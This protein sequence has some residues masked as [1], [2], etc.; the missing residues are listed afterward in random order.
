M[1]EQRLRLLIVYIR[2]YGKHSLAIPKLS[3]SDRAPF[4]A[5]RWVPVK[6]HTPTVRI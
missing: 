4:C 6:T 5:D 2:V 3:D 1:P